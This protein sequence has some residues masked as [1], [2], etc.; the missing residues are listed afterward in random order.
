MLLLLNVTADADRH[1]IVHGR[2]LLLVHLLAGILLLEL[3]HTRLAVLVNRLAAK[4]TDLLNRLLR[5]LIHGRRLL[6][7]LELLLLIVGQD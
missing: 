6:E 5:L 3:V 1:T 7:H 4:S 2:C